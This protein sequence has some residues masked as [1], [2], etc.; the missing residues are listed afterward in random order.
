MALVSISMSMD[1]E[2]AFFFPSYH[3]LREK[4]GRSTYLHQLQSSHHHLFGLRGTHKISG[5][6]KRARLAKT[7][8]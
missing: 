6:F 2:L 8:I 1:S 3:E 5:V 7:R 4:K